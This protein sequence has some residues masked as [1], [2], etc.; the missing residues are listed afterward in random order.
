M[1]HVVL[2]FVSV[3]IASAAMTAAEKPAVPVA[4]R[5]LAKTADV[6]ISLRNAV[7]TVIAVKE[8]ASHTAHAVVLMMTVISEAATRVAVQYR[9]VWQESVLPAQTINRKR[10]TATPQAIDVM[11]VEMV[12]GE[13]V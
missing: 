9:C 5:K 8:H 3:R 13:S 4:E 1:E 2:P 10:V 12:H 11:L 6:K 7:V